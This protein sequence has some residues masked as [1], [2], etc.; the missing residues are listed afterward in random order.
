MKRIY[1]S[2]HD[3][4][5]LFGYVKAMLESQGIECTVTGEHAGELAGRL[6]AR[7]LLW[8]VDDAKY[9]EAVKIMR[10]AEATVDGNTTPWRCPGCGEK[11]DGQFAECWKCGVNRPV[12]S[13]ENANVPPSQ[14]T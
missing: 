6:P 14:S 11:I 13:P 9:E 10:T 3:A 1:T 7:P 5:P 8:V 12:A 2:L 4:D